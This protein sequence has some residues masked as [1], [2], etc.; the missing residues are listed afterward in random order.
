MMSTVIHI[1]ISVKQGGNGKIERGDWKE[2]RMME[3]AGLRQFE[4]MEAVQLHSISPQLSV[5]QCDLAH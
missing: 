4:A 3:T 2:A 1:G 5:R